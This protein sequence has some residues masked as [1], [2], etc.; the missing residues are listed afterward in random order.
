MKLTS[1]PGAKMELVESSKSEAAAAVHR[2]SANTSAAQTDKIVYL[3]MTTP[4]WEGNG[5]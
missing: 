3:F 1:S 5:I 4:P 2:H